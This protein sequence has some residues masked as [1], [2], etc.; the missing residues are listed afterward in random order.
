MQT[1]TTDSNLF[2]EQG[3]LFYQHDSGVVFTTTMRALQTA[4]ENE[5]PFAVSYTAGL[6]INAT[7]YSPDA[8]GPEGRLV[9]E[10]VESMDEHLE[11]LAR[12]VDLVRAAADTRLRIIPKPGF[13][14]AGG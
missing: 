9:F 1:K 14:A 12:A 4:S 8:E 11:G 3:N 5:Q 13:T 6:P 7:D 10:W 2:I